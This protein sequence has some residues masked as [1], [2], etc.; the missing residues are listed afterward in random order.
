MSD[1][2]PPDATL[3]PGFPAWPP[4]TGPSVNRLW[5]YLSNFADIGVG[6]VASTLFW[7][8]LVVVRG[9]VIL[10]EHY[11]PANFD[12]WWQQLSGDCA[13]V[14][15][16]LNHV[17]L[18]DVFRP[19]QPAGRDLTLYERVGQVVRACWRCRLREA[20]PARSFVVDYAT[21]PEEYGPTVTFW[22]GRLPDG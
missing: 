1:I 11:E 6:A 21:E 19:V 17:H 20:F 18:Y 7:P 4:G 9:C 22:Q 15:R 5:G 8:D 13:A 2:L 12:Q 10:A 16:V 14:E 3:I